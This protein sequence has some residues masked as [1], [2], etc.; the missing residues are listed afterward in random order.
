VI[1]PAIKVTL[2][3]GIRVE[4]TGVNSSLKVIDPSGNKS[5]QRLLDEFISELA[6]DLPR[7]MQ[8]TSKEKAQTL[9]KIIGV[10]DRLFELEA[11]EQKLYLRR[12][13]VGRMADSKRKYADGL[14]E[15]PDA[16]AKPVSAGELIQ[17]QQAILARNGENQR[18]R[19]RA[20][21]LS[22]QQA[23][24]HAEVERLKAELS[25]KM[26]SL[27][28][29]NVDL[30]S[31]QK[32]VAQ[33]HDE[34]TA[35]LEA[36]IVA[37]DDINA[38]VRANAEKERAGDEAAEYAGQYN[39]LTEKIE[40]VRNQKIALL[41]GAALP[42]PGLS[43]ENGELT[44]QGYKWD[45]LSGADQLRIGASIVRKLNP[46]CGFVLMDKLEQMDVDTLREFGAWLESEG[47]QVIATRV[48]TGDECSIVIDDGYAASADVAT[49]PKQ[50]PVWKAGEF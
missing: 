35:E 23:A 39:A 48:S 42:L 13:E 38:K 33:L 29:L 7:F 20:E 41:N 30:Q 16:P 40:N 3:N 34:S 49:A 15:Y 8:S 47:L 22:Q 32:S 46:N 19:L 24:L 26:A 31:A 43:V 6:L 44:Y 50:M 14:P 10:G 36:S 2:S 45:N 4:R 17:Q 37:I 21:Q 5:G 28:T 12:T 1:P 9:L 25:A 11:E 18:L 27:E